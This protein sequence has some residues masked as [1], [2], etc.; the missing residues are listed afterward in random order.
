[1][2]FGEIQFSRPPAKAG[3]AAIP[4]GAA[5]ANRLI[6]AAALTVARDHCPGETP[7]CYSCTSF[8]R[9]GEDDLRRGIIV[10]IGGIIA[11]GGLALLAGC[12]NQGDKASNAAAKPKPVGP[13]YHIA[14]GAPPAKPN[15]AGITI[16]AIN[17]TA[18]PKLVEKR[19]SLVVRFDT[20]T[21]SKR[22]PMVNQMVMAPVDISG[23]AGAIPADYLAAA[24][25][26]LSRYLGAYCVN[27]KIKLSVAL[28]RSSLSSQAGDAEI[29]S[30]RLTDWLPIEIVFKN[31]HPTC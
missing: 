13:P 29:D 28:A 16:P 5:G 7:K 8:D 12:A 22:G 20:A 19:A 11:I 2:S 30:K 31:P 10:A 14:F 27:G 4:M 23:A 9:Y 25:K 26:E 24:D 3:N 15:P 18:N 1:M 6:P 21:V 17:Y